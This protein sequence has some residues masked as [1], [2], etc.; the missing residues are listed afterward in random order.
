[1]E[2]DAQPIVRD[3]D[4]EFDF[5]ADGL[6]RIDMDA[7]DQH[8]SPEEI[9]YLIHSLKWAADEATFIQVGAYEVGDIIYVDDKKYSVESRSAMRSGGYGPAHVAYHG[10]WLNRPAGETPFPSRV[11]HKDVTR[12]ERGAAASEVAED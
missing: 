11:L 6:V 1:M 8:R 2:P 12:V 4:D 5:T 7:P 10:D 9:D 3:F